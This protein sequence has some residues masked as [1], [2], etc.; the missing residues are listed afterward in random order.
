MLDNSLRTMELQCQERVDLLETL[1]LSRIEGPRATQSQT[2][3]SQAERPGSSRRQTEGHL[4]SASGPTKPVVYV[5][6]TR[7]SDIRP[8][9]P[10]RPSQSR[11][12]WAPQRS[13][14]AP[15]GGS[16]SPY[17]PM[18]SVVYPKL[19]RTPSP[20]KRTAFLT[21]LRTKKPMR[22]SQLIPNGTPGTAAKAAGLAWGS[23]PRG[24]EGTEFVRTG[25]AE[26][27][28]LI[29]ELQSQPNTSQPCPA[30]DHLATQ[31][32]AMPDPQMFCPL[33]EHVR[34]SEDRVS[35]PRARSTTVQ[36][37]RASRPPQVP[38]HMVPPAVATTFPIDPSSRFLGGT[39]SEPSPEKME[40][41]LS[42]LSLNQ[43]SLPLSDK[44]H[45]VSKEAQLRRNSLD[46]E[47]N[48]TGLVRNCIHRKPVP[49]SSAME[50]AGSNS[51]YSSQESYG[52]YTPTDDGE[53]DDEGGIEQEE[54][55][56][57]VE[58]V[59]GKREEND[60]GQK[61][62]TR[63]T[64]LGLLHYDEAK[65]WEERVYQALKHLDKGVDT[66]AVN[67]IINEIVVKGDEVHWDDVAGLE[68]AK[69]ALKEAV[70]Y[71]FL[72]PDLFRG[73]REPARGMLLFGPPGTGKVLNHQTCPYQPSFTP[74]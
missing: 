65:T 62:T 7:S 22:Q 18:Q 30:I 49:T 41:R 16:L 25:L 1:K 54:K 32:V 46:C 52:G 28:M 57:E 53:G 27:T 39:N 37:E 61:S 34:P 12:V 74:Y 23:V 47:S 72:R 5:S 38:E 19:G 71:P 13:A 48:P 73:L 20:D 40:R 6:S 15:G 44:P 35:R 14:T 29:K 24:I 36:P 43:T 8:P 2:G 3:Q 9:L 66:E 69:M 55:G 58:R 68:V 64:P 33:P 31:F 51:S 21:T 17:P 50:R 60:I 11:Q 70:V 4:S 56:Q 67:Q 10:Q 26:S 45:H 59:S 42:E 63:L